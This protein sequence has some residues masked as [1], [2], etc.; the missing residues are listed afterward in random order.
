MKNRK[1]QIGEKGEY[2][3]RCY[4]ETNGYYIVEQNWRCRTGE[5]DLIALK[6]SLL[7][8]IEV[9][10]RSVNEYFGNPEESVD[11]RKQSKIRQTTNYYLSREHRWKNRTD[12]EI[13]FDV[14]AVWVNRQGE[15]QRL[16]HYP[17]A[18]Q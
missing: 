4:L 6:D 13:R 7:A 14:I 10:T 18:F 11:G 1:Q 16:K 9:R 3:A 5:I 15:L 8:I 12:L 17:D 2:Y